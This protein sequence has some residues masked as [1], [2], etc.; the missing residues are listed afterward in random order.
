MA[1]STARTR[2]IRCMPLLW[3]FVPA[4]G[5][6]IF[7][8]GYHPEVQRF[9][10]DF[11]ADQL[12]DYTIMPPIDNNGGAWFVKPTNKTRV[13]KSKMRLKPLRLKA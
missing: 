7:E 13:D 12:V 6:F 2:N 5:I 4:G 1:T 10:R 3:D 9:W 11:C 8:D